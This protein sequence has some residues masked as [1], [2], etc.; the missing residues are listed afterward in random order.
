MP[1]ARNNDPPTKPFAPSTW[2]CPACVPSSQSKVVLS[3]PYDWRVGRWVRLAESLYPL[4][5]AATMT[6]IR[7]PS[8]CHKSRVVARFAGQRVGDL[9]ARR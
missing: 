5:L 9:L 1:I 4:F 2:S 7:R 6:P 3:D 8:A